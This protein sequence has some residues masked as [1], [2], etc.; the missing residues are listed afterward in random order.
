M[1]LFIRKDNKT[2]S[3]ASL[4][5]AALLCCA[6]ALS[7]CGGREAHPIAATNVADSGMDCGGVSREF[8]ANERQILAT[9]KERSQ[10]QGKNVILGATGVLLFWPALFFMDPK[11]PEKVEIDALRNRN[12]VLTEL[13]RSRKC[14]VPKSQLGEVY[15]KLD[16]GVKTTPA[17][18]D[19]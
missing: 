1:G 9:V 5:A 7:S 4:P 10:A 6:I 12:Q 2:A 3:S 15:K 16:G 18:R 13:A 11:S 17:K 14:P 19:G 8:E